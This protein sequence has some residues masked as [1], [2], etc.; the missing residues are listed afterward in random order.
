MKK[1]SQSKQ[2]Q[3]RFEDPSVDSE[4]EEELTSRSIFMMI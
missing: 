1:K 2:A 3:P 4:E